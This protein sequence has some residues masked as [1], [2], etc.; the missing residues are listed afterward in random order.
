MWRLFA[1]GLPDA[2][3]GILRFLNVLE[4]NRR[5]LSIT[6]VGMWLMLFVMV[7]VMVVSPGDVVATATAVGGQLVATGAYAIKRYQE[8][9]GWMPS[10]PK[11]RKRIDDDIPDGLT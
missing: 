7:Y 3:F 5:V 2:F 10:M 6:N 11:P 9:G 1:K 4:R 8:S